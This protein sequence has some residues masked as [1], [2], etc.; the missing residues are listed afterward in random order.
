MKLLYVINSFGA[1]GAER[2]LL[3]MVRDM[4]ARGHIVKVAALSA[5][6]SGG[7]RDLR[8]E[9]EAA[10]A[11]TNCLLRSASRGL[12][13]PLLWL[14]LLREVDTFLPDI[15]HSHLPRADF[16]A[17]IV[18]M[19][20]PERTWVCTLHDAYIKGVYS[21]YRIFPFLSWAW[22]RANYIVAVSRHAE[23]WGYETLRLRGERVSVIYHGIA[24]DVESKSWLG[25]SS[26]STFNIGCLARFEPRKGLA[27]LVRSLPWIHA[28]APFAKLLLAGSDPGG[29][30]DKIKQL[31]KELD[32]ADA[33]NIVGFAEK[34]LEFLRSLD[35]FAFASYSEGFGI[36]L[37]EAMAV[38]LPVV[39]S[40]IYPINYIVENG[41]TG[42][43][44][45]PNDPRAFGLAL[46]ELLENPKKARAMG[47]NGRKR[48]LSEFSEEKM[49][50]AHHA[51]YMSLCAD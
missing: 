34:P 37:L 31:A 6:I 50:G 14:R 8:P 5:S 4:V 43:L 24:C 10:G 30:A 26:T 41:E 42:I 36:V 17:S 2:H 9:F 21:G 35:V 15:V 22:R 49:T 7:A 38:G 33:V 32:V 45:D 11:A 25:S 46:L 1:G 3:V 51:I 39:A 19:L 16:A 29:F 13:E 40:D 12:L 27:T 48:C 44:V 23:R 47:E 20:R 18:K 28:K